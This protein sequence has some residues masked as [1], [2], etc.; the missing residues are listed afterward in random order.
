MAN[1]KKPNKHRYH[2]FIVYTGT[3][4]VTGSPVSLS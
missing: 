4:Y 2:D 3:W 1:E